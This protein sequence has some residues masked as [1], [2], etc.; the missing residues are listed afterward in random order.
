MGTF[1]DTKFTG[2]IYTRGSWALG[3]QTRYKKIYRFDGNFSLNYNVQKLNDPDFPDF[4]ELSNFFVRWN[5]NQD[6]KARP[7]SRFN[8]SVN[9]GSTGNFQNNLNTSQT[10]FL[11][12]TFN[13]SINYSKTFPGRPFSFNASASHSQNSFTKDF[14][15][16]L[17]AATF[18]LSRIF[19][20]LSFLRTNPVGSEKWF[21]KIGL[22]YSSSLENNLDVKENQLKLNE[23]YKL[24][25]DFKNGINHTASLSTSLK[26]WYFNINPNFSFSDRMYFSTIRKSFEGDTVNISRVNG[27]RQSPDYSFGASVNTKIFG[28]V[29][30]NSNKIKAIRH[31]MTPSASYSYSPKLGSLESYID[32]V[33]KKIDYSIF[34][35]AIYGSSSSLKAQVISVS[36][37]NNLEMKVATKKDTASDTRI[38]KLLENLSM[39]SS[40]SILADSLNWSDITASMRTPIYKTV[41][42]TMAG[43]YSP[44]SFNADGDRINESLLK[45]RGQL[46]RMNRVSGTIDANLQSKNQGEVTKKETTEAT[47]EDLE[48][49]ENN[50]GL[51]VDFTVPWSLNFNYQAAVSKTY[52]SILLP[53]EKRVT[54]THSILFNGDFKLVDRVKVGFNSGYDFQLK[55]FTTTSLNLYIDLNCW[56][57]TAGY[58]PFGLRKSYNFAI[59]IKTSILKDLKIQK[60]GNLGDEFNTF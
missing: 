55:D 56:E 39:N 10:N 26:A 58:I 50:K 29:R 34:E 14:N 17:P 31:V 15:F 32:S 46:L 19:L 42:L 22:N 8:A 59:N 7:D 57:F 54:F 49:I 43:N 3:N 21:E 20:P 24:T 36:L 35:E 11:T 37:V 51:F 48:F 60:R 2:D 13:S 12:N 28:M 1:A 9:A 16:K 25:D 41:G 45:D 33:G 40:Y 30:F 6:P 47:E 4:A 27:F 44:Y 38:L 18:N 23:L 5:H 52:Q 53:G